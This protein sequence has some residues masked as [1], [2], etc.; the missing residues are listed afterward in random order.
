MRRRVFP[1]ALMATVAA[2]AACSG[3][4]P[5]TPS[6]VEIL[7]QSYRLVCDSWS[8]ATPPV[9][10]TLMDIRVKGQGEKVS[11]EELETLRQN[12]ADIV[13]QFNAGRLVRV[14]I[15][16]A[17]V[18]PLFKPTFL[19]KGDLVA[20]ATTVPDPASFKVDMIATLD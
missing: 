20:Y 13:R 9:T 3:G 14:A 5:T 12:S 7:S 2:A 16:V 11:E 6:P 1:A 18:F 15:D 10:R 8:P 19:P 17:R 4:S